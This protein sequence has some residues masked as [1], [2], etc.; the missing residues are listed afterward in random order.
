M[1]LQHIE[2]LK[3]CLHSLFESNTPIIETI[4]KRSL[5]SVLDI[6]P[7]ESRF[8]NGQN[9]LIFY[10]FGENGKYKY[11]TNVV[12]NGNIFILQTFLLGWYPHVWGYCIDGSVPFWEVQHGLK[13]VHVFLQVKFFWFL[14]ACHFLQEKTSKLVRNIHIDCSL[15]RKKPGF[16]S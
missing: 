4:V 1:Q 15:K 9:N 2:L 7:W 5:Y 13:L 16:C 10:L 14:L 12:K 3:N 11:R 6:A 8:Q